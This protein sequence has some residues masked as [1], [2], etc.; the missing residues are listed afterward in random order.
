MAALAVVIVLGDIAFDAALEWN[1]EIRSDSEVLGTWADN[2]E[3]ITLGL[4][5]TF[6]YRSP[7]QTTTG[8]WARQDWNLYLHGDD[9][10][11]TMRF[12][13]FSGHYRLMTHPPEDPDLWDGNLG[14][15]QRRSPSK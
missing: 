10:S 12:V 14:L 3:T 4:D 6:T 8:R 5:N 2:G 1:P 11:T 15:R 9:Y 7:S 13:Q